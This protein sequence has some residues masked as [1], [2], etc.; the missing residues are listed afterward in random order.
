MGWVEQRNQYKKGNTLSGQEVEDLVARRVL[1]GLGLVQKDLI[2]VERHLFGEVDC[3]TPIWPRVLAVWK[4]LLYTKN[5]RYFD[6]TT[7]EVVPYDKRRKYACITERIEDIDPDDIP[8]PV[9]FTRIDKTGIAFIPMKPRDVGAGMKPPYKV[10]E[11]V[12]GMHLAVQE[13]EAY[14]SGLGPYGIEEL[15]SDD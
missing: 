4:R 10:V 8:R 15:L 11:E 12:N 14:V 3:D 1:R 9:F 2:R 13:I 5:N 6:V 7:V